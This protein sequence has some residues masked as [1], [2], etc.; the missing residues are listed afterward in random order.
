MYAEMKITRGRS[1][2]GIFQGTI[3]EGMKKP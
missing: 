1:H 2:H 3:L